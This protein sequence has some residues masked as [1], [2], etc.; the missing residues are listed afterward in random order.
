[1]RQAHLDA[2]RYQLN[3]HLLFNSLNAV[4]TLVLQGNTAAATRMLAQIGELLR[5]ALDRKSVV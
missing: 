3:P 1:M 2:L 4:S 5:S